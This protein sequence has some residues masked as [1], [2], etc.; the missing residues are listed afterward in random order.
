LA[1]VSATEQHIYKLFIYIYNLFIFSA[2]SSEHFGNEHLASANACE[3]KNFSLKW[4]IAKREQCTIG[5]LINNFFVK[6]RA[7]YHFLRFWHLKVCMDYIF[8]CLH[9]CLTPLILHYCDISIFNLL[10]HF[11]WHEFVAMRKFASVNFRKSDFFCLSFWNIVRY[12]LEISLEISFAQYC[13]TTKK[14][15]QNDPKP[16]TLIR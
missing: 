5:T 10:F 15:T 11:V 2:R 12:F 3:T 14:T 6:Q 7:F 16:C 9:V 8:V 13:T 1:R 4:K